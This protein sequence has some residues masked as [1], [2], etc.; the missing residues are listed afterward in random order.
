M[1][2]LD[3]ALRRT[4]IN[5]LRE[6]GLISEA[7]AMEREKNLTDEVVGASEAV[8]TA[9]DPETEFPRLREALDDWYLSQ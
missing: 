8:L 4:T 1:Q 5:L 6:L 2:A 9:E 3:E 7:E